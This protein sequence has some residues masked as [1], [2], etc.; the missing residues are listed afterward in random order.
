MKRSY[1]MESASFHDANNR[2]GCAQ[3]DPHDRS[4]R[5]I[6]ARLAAVWGTRLGYMSEKKRATYQH[7]DHKKF[8][9]PWRHLGT[10]SKVLTSLMCHVSAS[11]RMKTLVRGK[12]CH[13]DGRFGNSRMYELAREERVADKVLQTTQ[14]LPVVE[15]D[16]NTSRK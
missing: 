15:C 1:D 12:R 14:D 7:Q 11:S 16:M 4:E 9:H 8:S 2:V 13:D 6:R 5:S 3:I 10:N